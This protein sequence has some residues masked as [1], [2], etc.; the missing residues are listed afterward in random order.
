MVRAKKQG[1]L[2]TALGRETWVL[3]TRGGLQFLVTRPGQLQPLGTVVR[4][5]GN[6]YRDVKKP[7]PRR[8]LAGSGSTGISVPSG[9][10]GW[11]V[12]REVGVVGGGT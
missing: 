10:A 7:T 1:H 3:N 11:W 6:L 12:P 2:R 5:R 9:V 4:E 8:A